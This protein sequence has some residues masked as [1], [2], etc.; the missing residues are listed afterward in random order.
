MQKSVLHPQQQDVIVS[1]TP[2]LM[3]QG[4]S[5][6][7]WAGSLPSRPS[8][9]PYITLKN[10]EEKKSKIQLVKLFGKLLNVLNIILCLLSF[11]IYG[12]ITLPAA[13]QPIFV[14]LH[15]LCEKDLFNTLQTRAKSFT[16]QM[17][18]WPVLWIQVEKP[19]FPDF[20]EDGE[21]DQLAAGVKGS[22]KK[23]GLELD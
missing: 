5:R 2:E 19:L 10:I 18:F 16:L 6:E 23:N 12:A 11:L 13:T 3:V 9:V 21:T 7:L 17:K 22:L 20:L 8:W 14:R 4:L 15:I 1:S